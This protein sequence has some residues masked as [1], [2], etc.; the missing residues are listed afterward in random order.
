MK[1]E[2]FPA[3][4]RK[5]SIE[6]RGLLLTLACS[7]RN[8]TWS[9][10]EIAAALSV[11]AL[12][13]RSFLDTAIAAKVFTQVGSGYSLVQE[14]VELRKSWERLFH[15][16]FWPA[17]TSPWKKVGRA[18]ALK[19]WNSQTYGLINP[20]TEEAANELC[21]RIMRGME[22]YKKLLSQPNAPSM[23]YPEGWLSGQRWNDEIDD[24]FI[25]QHQSVQQPSISSPLERA[26]RHQAAQQQTVDVVVTQSPVL[27]LPVKVERNEL[28][29]FD[30]AI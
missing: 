24:Q 10:M 21:N 18:N 6:D 11:D 13:A 3:G 9:E 1:P 28:P 16:V 2:S 30:V 8:Q 5:L 14:S 4:W 7:T 20:R 12:R 23:K 22:Q 29:D 17:V 15:E 27:A 19:V 25:E 26:R